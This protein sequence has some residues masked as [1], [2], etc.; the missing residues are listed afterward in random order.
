M[1]LCDSIHEIKLIVDRIAACDNLVASGLWEMHRYISV[2]CRHRDNIDVY[3]EAFSN[4][5]ALLHD[6]DNLFSGLYGESLPSMLFKALR[7]WRMNYFSSVVSEGFVDDLISSLIIVE[8]IVC[9]Q[10]GGV[11]RFAHSV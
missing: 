5:M 8:T 10:R 11:A 2:I 1:G 4:I 9:R 3:E 6:L 7:E